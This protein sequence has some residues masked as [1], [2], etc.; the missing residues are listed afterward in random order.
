MSNSEVTSRTQNPA[1]LKLHMK[2]LKPHRKIHGTLALPGDK[3]I[4]HRAALLSLLTEDTLRIINYSDGEDCA[5]SLDAVRSLGCTVERQSESTLTIKPPES[6]PTETVKIDCG[7]SGTTARL[8]TG[9]LSGLD[10]PAEIVG[11]DSLSKRPMKRIVEPLRE[12][13]ARFDDSTETLPLY[14]LGGAHGNLEYRMPVASAQVKSSILF[15]ACAGGGGAAVIED[16]RTRDHSERMLKHLG[17]TIETHSPRIELRADSRDPRKKTRTV[18][19]DWKARIVIKGNG[20][21]SGGDIDIPGDMSTAAFFFAA[22]AIGKGEVTIENLG[23]NPTRT[24]FLDHLRAIGCE[25][26]VESRVT[27]SE[28]PRGV[29]TVR[30][31]K[32]KGRKISGALSAQLIDEIPIIAVMACFSDGPTLIRDV[33]ELRVKECDRLEA[34]IENLRRMGAKVGS[35][36]NDGIVVE[37]KGEMQ[38]AD[39]KS[40]GD[41]RI[42]MALSVASLFLA[43]ES[44]IDDSECVGV[45]CPRFYEML[46]SIKR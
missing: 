9:I 18:L 33:A 8:L 15:A 19:D 35:V 7:N 45:S 20:K 40:F 6:F 37:A 5:A 3:S 41:H 27:I 36:E 32:L 11:D 34:L 14:P 30:G 24:A 1:P 12:L 39:F 25:T 22:A 38:P 17:A 2:T 44:T 26:H 4:S 16:V 23:L 42:A 29:V 43:G 13:G 28:E 46:D 21:L 10:I 31:G